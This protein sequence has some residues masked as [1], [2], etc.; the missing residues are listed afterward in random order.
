MET[1]I[2][3][4][5]VEFVPA[6]Q[7]QIDSHRATCIDM[8][9]DVP[10]YSRATFARFVSDDG[11]V[12]SLPYELRGTMTGV[13]PEFLLGFMASHV[14]DLE[15]RTVYS[16]EF[17]KS[18][19]A[20]ESCAISLGMLDRQHG[21]LRGNYSSRFAQRTSPLPKPEPEAYGCDICREMRMPCDAHAYVDVTYSRRTGRHN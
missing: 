11:D 13:Q 18:G 21:I 2:A 14:E 1:R 4:Y 15:E 12:M 3:G 20:C 19:C 7:E 5:R 9:W 10:D 6:T 17:H 8:G 16:S